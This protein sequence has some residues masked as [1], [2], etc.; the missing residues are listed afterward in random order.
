MWSGGARSSDGFRALVFRLALESKTFP[1]NKR[2][3]VEETKSRCLSFDG[4]VCEGLD[5]AQTAL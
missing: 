2:D 3:A 1:R 4:A 5:P